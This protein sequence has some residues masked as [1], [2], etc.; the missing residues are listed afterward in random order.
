MESRN[1]S[2][3]SVSKHRDKNNNNNTDIPEF[4]PLSFYYIISY[5]T[6]KTQ[7]QK[8]TDVDRYLKHCACIETN[9]L[10]KNKQEILRTYSALSN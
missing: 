5:M 8:Q 2:S 1:T 4:R 9:H 7:N 10:D 3:S 6:S